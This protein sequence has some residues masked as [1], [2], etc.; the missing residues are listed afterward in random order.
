MLLALSL[1]ANCAILNVSVTDTEGKPAPGVIFQIFPGSVGVDDNVEP[2]ELKNRRSDSDAIAGYATDD[3]GNLQLDFEDGFYTLVGSSEDQHFLFVE[4]V[5]VPCSIAISAADAVPVSVS[6]RA[7]DESPLQAA[8]VF[9]RPTKR[10]R[11]DVGCTDNSGLLKAYVSRG[12]YHAVLQSNLG[13]TPHH[14]ILPY[15]MIAP[16]SAKVNFHSAE[17]PTCDLYFNL[18]KTAVIATIE[19]LEST[20]TSEYTK[21]VEIEVGYDILYTDFYSLINATHPYILSAG[22]GYKFSMS[23]VSLFGTDAIYAYELLPMSPDFYPVNPGVQRIGISDG[24]S[25]TLQIWS[26]RGDSNPIYHPGDWATLRYEFRDSSGNLLH[27]I[28]NYGEARL[29]LPVVTIWDSDGVSIANNFGTDSFSEFRFALPSSAVLGEY[30][31]EITL[32][33]GIYG[34]LSGDFYFNVSPVADEIPP[35]IK[36]VDIASKLEAGQEFTAAA[37]I[38]DNISLADYPTLRLSVDDGAS[39]TEINMTSVGGD[40]YQAIVPADLLAP[41][42]LGWQITAND[43][44]GNSVEQSGGADI[45]DTLPPVIFHELLATAELGYELLIQARVEDN[46]AVEGATLFYATAGETAESIEM[47]AAG[48][49]YSASIP[50]AEITFDGASYYIRAVDTAGNTAFLSAETDVPQF[51][52]VT[53]EDTIAPIIFHTPVSVGVANTPV[54]IEAIITDNSGIVEATLF[55]RGAG[56]QD[57]HSVRMDNQQGVYFADIPTEAESMYYRITAS[58]GVDPDGNSRLSASPA[59]GDYSIEISSEPGNAL[60]QLEVIP[61]E[62]L[63]VAAGASIEFTATGRDK[64]GGPL[65][66]DVVWSA[67][68]GIGHID[69][70]GSFLA[71]GR[72]A[73]DGVGKITATARHTDA[74]DTVLQAETWIRVCPGSPYRI[75]LNPGSAVLEAGDSLRFFAAVTDE[76][77]NPVPIEIN[78]SVEGQIGTVDDGGFDASKSGEGYIVAEAGGIRAVSQITVVHG[79]LHKIVIS[80]SDVGEITAGET[81]QFSAEG[82]DAFGNHIHIAPAWSV[83]GGVGTISGDGLF[84]GGTAGIGEV[85]AI[86]GDVSTA[87]DIGVVPGDLY[88]VSVSP[89]IAYLPLSTT[90]YNT[91]QQF[92]ADGWDIAGN[93]IPLDSISWVTDALAGNISASGLFTAI[94]TGTQLGSVVTNG[95]IWATGESPTGR[96]RVGMG[97][98]VV[99]KTPASQM[100]S[101]SVFIQGTSGDSGSVPIAIGESAQF[102]AV[103]SDAEGQKLSINPSWSVEGGVGDIDVNGLFTAARSGSGAIVATAGGFTGRAQVQITPGSLKSIA[104]RPDMLI[105]PPG[106]QHPLTAVGYDSSENVVPLENHDVHWSV[107]GQSA[108]I[109]RDGEFCTVISE[110]SG[111][112]IVRV[113]VGDVVGFANI[114]VSSSAAYESKPHAL[115]GD[116]PYYL[117]IEPELVGVTV[118]SQQ[119][120][121]AHAVDVLGGERDPGVLSWSVT[122]GIG[123]INSTGLFIAGNESGLGRVVVTD[124]KTF[125][126]AGVIVSVS[127]E[128]AQ[129]LLIT[130]TEIALS[131]GTA[132]KIMSFVKTPNG[133]LMPALSAWRVIGNIGSIDAFGRF[134][135]TAAGEG[136]IEATT[137]GLSARCDVTVSAGAPVSMDI[138]PNSLLIAAGEQEKFS[139]VCRDEAGNQADCSPVFQTTGNSGIISDNGLFT[140]QRATA[141]NVLAVV[142]TGLLLKTADIE[143]S[144]GNLAEIEIIPGDQVVLAGGSVRFSAV[145]RDACGNVTPVSP[146]WDV[147]ASTDVGSVSSNGLFIANKVGQGQVRAE[148]G[149]ITASVSVEVRAAAPAFILV[150]P[151]LALIFSQEAGAKQFSSTFLDLRGNV[152]EVA[153]DVELSWAVTEGLG[154]ID[155]QTGLFVNEIILDEPRTG[156]VTATAV[157]NEGSEQ[158]RTIRGRA[159]VTLNPTAKPLASIIVTPDSVLT[160]KG[161]TRKFTAAGRNADG[162]EVEVHPSWS[163][164]SDDSGSEIPNAIS[165][166]GVFSATADMEIGSSWRIRASAT[167][168]ANQL[169]QGEARLTL[170]AGPLQSIELVCDSCAAPI[171]SGQQIEIKAA[172]YDQFHNQV[173]IAPDWTVAGGIG[174][175]KPVSGTK[176][177][178]IFTAG[179]AGSG[180]A[181]AAIEGKE[182]KVH[183]TVIPGR[184]A[185]IAVSTIPAPPDEN[186]GTNETN[187]LVVKSGSEVRFAAVGSDSDVDVLGNSKPVNAVA[188]SPAWSVISSDAAADL[189]SISSDGRFV[190]KEVGAGRITA[191]ADSITG[192]FYIQVIA[193]DLASIRVSP[194]P[195]SVVSGAKRQFSSSG[196]DLHGNEIS[197]YHPEWHTTGD[198]GNI[199]ANGLFTPV[200]LPAGSPPVAGT[201]VAS[202]GAVQGA[203][204]V[205]VVSAL[206]KLAVISVSVEPSI[207]QAGGKA[208]C[209]IRGADDQGHSIADL[210]DDLSVSVPA[211]LGVVEAAVTSNEWIFR[212]DRNLPSNSDDRIGLLT[213]EATVDGEKLSADAVITLIPAALS[214]IAVEPEEINLS[215]GSTAT[216]EAKGYDTWGNQREL[217]ALEWTVTGVVGNITPDSQTAVFAAAVAGQGQLIASSQGYEGRSEITVLPGEAESLAIEPMEITIA[218]GS[219]HSFAGTGEDRYE[220]EIANLE[221]DWQ[222]TGSIGSITEGGVFTA[223]KTGTGGLRATYNGA[224]GAVNS[225][226][227]SI[228]VIPGSIASAG[229][230]I[231]QAGKMLEP[232][233]ALPS[234]VQYDLRVK[235][236]DALGNSIPHLEKAAWNVA[237]NTGLIESSQE[238]ASAAVLTTLFPGRGRISVIVDAVSAYLEIEVVPHSQ[239]VSSHTGATVFGPFGSSIKIPANAL[240]ADETISISLAPSPGSAEGARRT[241][242]VYS[243]EPDGLI[244]ETSVELTLPSESD[245]EKLSLYFWDKFQEKWFKAGGKV[246]PHQKS[247]TAA[248]NYLSLFAIMLEEADVHDE[249]GDD[250]LAILDVQL[251]PNTYFAPEINRL[252]INYKIGGVPGQPVAVTINIYDIGGQL[253]RELIDGSPKYPG[254]NADQWDGTDETGET[255]K[256]GRYILLI[257][258]EIDGEK[259]N[260]VKHLAV[261]K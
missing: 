2:L 91:T 41:G 225:N 120:F 188:V 239:N 9:F 251:S 88:S 144:P 83:R 81:M 59:S 100:T 109:I 4:K 87:V 23:F 143:I 250:D 50:G 258:V 114:F 22:M 18:P 221:L 148:A 30:R 11:A 161:D 121:T 227:A 129:E 170:T 153:G 17:L 124:G 44:A 45:L 66:V 126:S 256:N 228:T 90:S 78:W 199:D 130:P 175:V 53:V 185:D 1:P 39:W 70:D 72:I 69:Q 220:N 37:S 35:W 253:I 206:G 142:P 52:P 203:A 169:I 160:I 60:A 260:K 177:A 196:Y 248:V 163:V 242:Y 244:F 97:Y 7:A 64:A 24:D 202:V 93:Q 137:R 246:N 103:G 13:T 116:H 122:G 180:E 10:A 190:G 247:V 249:P 80:P 200:S 147:Q 259:V 111:N 79:L 118:G 235:A 101:I 71:T 113:S 92:A 46:V 5:S 68:G 154:T 171:E 205:S 104:I 29:V 218:A 241:G 115:P 134:T 155:P 75:V 85:S 207:V 127:V 158:Q 54:K 33:G 173:E 184:L 28:L 181:T 238:D 74:H 231:Y 197:D 112:G 119:Q 208:V 230:V 49:I 61:S 166:D 133:E 254:R 236:A 117:E 48:E 106:A 107:E 232:P 157:I 138:Q 149:G 47:S 167:N 243:F 25:F 3:A 63:D 189:G 168:N 261:L 222:V 145:G 95:T 26:D 252:T 219:S 15:Q 216:F 191:E 21:G 14:L 229:I 195:V 125:G 40:L 27:R 56:E 89:Y 194:S 96:R 73:G 150:E 51:T 159:I 217:S 57:Y 99:Q 182:G 82:Y 12:V 38:L 186:A 16:P 141:S 43:P 123:E 32:E 234:G 164:V 139:V 86:V 179:L 223:E 42:K 183:I 19:T 20:Y 84:R 192:S 224:S 98:V 193:G 209:V 215:A 94:D 105:L 204:S 102:E 128:N 187:P 76:Y 131:S 67:T 151:A 136:E 198:I 110:N 178:A 146:A 211:R 172:G 62:S 58:D 210:P 135:A 152:V 255:V 233:F 132:Q 34:K 237:E 213:V 212:A 8:E 201:V 65:A 77:S 55:Y 31:A 108:K 176:D 226:E 214:R 240:R 6:C 156:C 162:G 245:D 36:S 174:I 165:A 140:A 257:T